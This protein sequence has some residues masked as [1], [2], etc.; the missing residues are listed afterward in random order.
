MFVRF[1]K[2][3]RKFAKRPFQQVS[4]RV[5][6]VMEDMM[7]R[8]N[9]T[10]L[11]DMLFRLSEIRITPFRDKKIQGVRHIYTTEADIVFER[12]ANCSPQPLFYDERRSCF[13]ILTTVKSEE[14]HLFAPLLLLG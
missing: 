10:R 3:H 14:C 8:L 11:I 2:A 5:A 4:K 6:T 12:G 9:R 13:R 7:K 1:E